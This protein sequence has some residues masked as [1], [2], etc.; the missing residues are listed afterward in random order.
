[1]IR[2]LRKADVNRVAKICFE[3]ISKKY[4]SN[5]FLSKRGV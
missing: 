2:E 3:C 4:T 5:I 1:M